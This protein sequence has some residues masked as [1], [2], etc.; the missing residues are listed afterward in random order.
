M[1]M[2]IILII[3]MKVFTVARLK[4]GETK[5]IIDKN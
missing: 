4:P 3:L 2:L 1:I 5:I